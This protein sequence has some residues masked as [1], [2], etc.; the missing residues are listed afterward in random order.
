MDEKNKTVTFERPL[1]KDGSIDN[2]VDFYYKKESN[3]SH[4]ATLGVYITAAAL[5]LASIDSDNESLRSAVSTFW[6]IGVGY[7]I[8]KK[9]ERGN[10]KKLE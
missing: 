9:L 8:G 6:T 1:K 2:D 10:Y 5:T 3:F 4:Y 7:V